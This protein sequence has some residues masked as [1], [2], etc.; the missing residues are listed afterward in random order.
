VNTRGHPSGYGRLPDRYVLPEL[1][2]VP[3][4]AVSLAHLEQLIGDLATD[5]KRRGGGDLHP[6][7]VK[8]AWEVGGQVFRYALRH[9]IA[10]R[11]TEVAEVARRQR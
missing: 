8:H 1:G 5:G 4:A 6:K 3:I 7:T 2:H 9:N 11:Q 10:G